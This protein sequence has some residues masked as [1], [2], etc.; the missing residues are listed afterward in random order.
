[1]KGP[2]YEKQQQHR[3]RE[4]QQENEILSHPISETLGEAASGRVRKRRTACLANRPR[5]GKA[6]TMWPNT[7]VNAP[8]LYGMD[9]AR[10]CDRTPGTMTTGAGF[11]FARGTRENRDANTNRSRP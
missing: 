11:I 3:Y 9:Y 6:G 2:Q 7:V 10:M 8:P 5:R 1:M 4:F